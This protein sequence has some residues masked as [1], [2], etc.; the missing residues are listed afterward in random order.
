M[1]KLFISLLLVANFGYAEEIWFESANE[2]GGLIILTVEKCR[3]EKPDTTLRQMYSIGTGG[4][5]IWGCWNYWNDQVH[6]VYDSG[7]SYT[8]NP[9]LFVKKTRP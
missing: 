9:E 7:R 8:Y 1:R 3:K 5:T 4:V 2:A 6:V